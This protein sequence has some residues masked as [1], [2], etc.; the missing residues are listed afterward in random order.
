MPTNKLLHRVVVFI[1][2]VSPLAGQVAT[3]SPAPLGKL[4]D[5]GGYRLHLHCTGQGSPT[6]VFEN[7]SADF[8]FV[9]DF[10]Q[11]DVSKFTRA[12]SYDRAG[13]AWSD[14]GPLPRSFEQ[15]NLEL[16]TALQ[17]AGIRGLYVLV[18]QSYGGF[19]VRAF[20]E[21]YKSEV[22]GVVLVDAAHENERIMMQGKVVRIRDMAKGATLPRP[23]LR[24]NDAEKKQYAELRRK[25]AEAGPTAVEPA[26][27]NLSPEDQKAELWAIVQ[28]FLATAVGSE[29]DSSQEE[30]AVWYSAKKI[31]TT[32][33]GDI[34]LVVISR[35]EGGYPDTPEVSG[36][37]LD[38]ER[39]EEQA[40]LTHLSRNSK[41]IIAEHSG[42]NIHL[43]D[44]A[45]VVQAIHAV[46]D[47]ARGKSKMAVGR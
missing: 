3:P 21:K 8:S 28:P 35:G 15:I 20:A 16:H 39:R 14:P 26:L 12:C 1:A 6:V 29:L 10:V 7:G 23:R 22:V 2:M 41:Q 11:P 38:Q 4:V 36:K 25:T 44:P 46:V 9:W 5:V 47:A 13:S 31:S 27:D 19:V 18:G 40:E 33:L 45:L 37:Q 32:P 43:E 42:H 34:S 24:L 30:I 17:K